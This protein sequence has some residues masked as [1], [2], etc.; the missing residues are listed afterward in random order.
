MTFLIAI[1]HTEAPKNDAL[2]LFGPCLIY[3]LNGAKSDCDMST[4]FH[5]VDS[6]LRHLFGV[7]CFG[8]VQN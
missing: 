5:S 8:I 1:S 2:T 6:H 3:F 7:L 4:S